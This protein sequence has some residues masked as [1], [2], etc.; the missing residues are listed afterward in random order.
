MCQNNCNTE[1]IKN[2][3]LTQIEL[4]KIEPK[5][6]EGYNVTQIAKYLGRDCSCIQKEIKKFSIVKPSQK[7]CKDCKNY[8]KCNQNKLCEYS[9]SGE[10][11]NTCRDCK[12]GTQLCKEYVPVVKCDRLKGRKKYV[13][14]AQPMD[15]DVVNLN[16]YIRQ[17]RHGNNTRKTKRKV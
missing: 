6:D 7:D 3:P 9:L 14:D 12:G 16:W 8:E 17:K 10:R 4:G 2:K 13:M 15:I 1:E 5:L 11:C